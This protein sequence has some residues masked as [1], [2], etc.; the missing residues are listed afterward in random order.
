MANSE[1]PKT[2]R[3][4]HVD[5]VDDGITSSRAR[6]LLLLSASLPRHSFT[7][8]LNFVAVSPSIRHQRFARVVNTMSFLSHLNPIPSFPSYTGPYN[9]GSQDVEIPIHELSTPSPPP[10]PE[11]TTSSF[12]LFYPCPKEQ[13]TTK[14]IHWLPDPQ[15]EYLKAYYSFLQAKPWLASLL[16]WIPFLRL[17]QYTTIP[18]IRDAELLEPPPKNEG[19]WPVMIFSHGLGGSRNAYSH[20]CGSLASHGMVVA[21][22]D[23]RD[24]S[25]PISFIKDEIKG[26][27]KPVNYQYYPHENTP[28]VEKGRNEQLKTR[29]WELGL[30]FDALLKIDNG[31]AVT[32]TQTS[33]ARDTLLHFKSRL[34]MHIPGKV[35]WTGHSFGATT[36]V[37]LLKSVYHKG[38]TLYPYWTETLASQITPSSPVSLLDLWAMPLTATS[39]A[40]LYNL[41]LPANSGAAGSNSSPPLAILSVG[42]YKWTTNFRHTLHILT[43]GSSSTSKPPYI[44]Y[45]LSSAHL[46]Q[47]DFG[48]LFPWLTKRALKV[49][50]PERALSLNVRAILESL[51]R[52]GISVADT[53]AL[54][55]E[56][57]EEGQD[58]TI[59]APEGKVRGWVVVNAKEEAERLGLGA[60]KMNGF[61]KGEPRSPDEAV[62]KFEANEE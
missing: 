14:H 35:S 27:L 16:T 55:Q 58:Q 46:S 54:D 21:A 37:Q 45:P 11:I 31:E 17:I 36:I 42:F 49:S 44:F 19:R 34:D 13:K 32:N 52:S 15:S 28:E 62:E 53:S 4:V 24:G 61:A 60:E 2:C 9:V 43:Q 10:N 59:L 47:S 18:A 33:E 22:P 51:R 41:P 40:S 57:E 23:H 3:D 26:K 6:W 50:E 39:T 1:I 7:P 30:A 5:C 20:I 38:S 12:R 48:L 25:A 8:R 56:V 29:C